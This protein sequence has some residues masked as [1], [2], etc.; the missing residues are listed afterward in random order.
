MFRG[1]YSK[2]YL[3]AYFRIVQFQFAYNCLANYY[4]TLCDIF[5]AAGAKE[6]NCS[7][8]GEKLCN[9]GKYPQINPVAAWCT[10]DIDRLSRER[11][12]PTDALANHNVQ[13]HLRQSGRQSRQK[14]NIIHTGA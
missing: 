13:L 14:T 7:P 4:G 11:Q 9:K 10:R 8:N 6:Y 5:C 1:V 2:V 3:Y 12:Q